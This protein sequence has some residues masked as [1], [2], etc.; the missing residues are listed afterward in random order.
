MLKLILGLFILS[1]IFLFVY[2]IIGFPDACFRFSLIN[3]ILKS[4]IQYEEDYKYIKITRIIYIKLL[5]TTYI[6][7]YGKIR[8]IFDIIILILPVILLILFIGTIAYMIG[9]ILI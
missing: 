3:K 2:T 8:L 5:I 4:K 9:D 7:K 6:D 1:L